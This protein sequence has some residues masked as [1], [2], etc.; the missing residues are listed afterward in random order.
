MTFSGYD[1]STINIV[2][3]L[4]LLLLSVGVVVVVVLMGSL[5]R[6]KALL[7][8]SVERSDMPGEVV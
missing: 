1:D 8:L 5:L 2:L 4:L 3:G 6:H 7:N